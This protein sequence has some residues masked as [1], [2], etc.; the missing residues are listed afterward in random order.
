MCTTGRPEA[1]RIFL[2]WKAAA[3]WNV[4][5]IVSMLAC[6]TVVAQNLTGEIDG[7]VRDASGS[8]IPNASITIRNA[9]Q[10]LVVRT[11]RSDQQGQFTV[12]LL[13]VGHYSLSAIAVGF[14]T[15]TINGIDVHVNQSV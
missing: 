15:A 10:N 6:S 9:D 2:R 13:A 8:A 14:Q 11:V 3:A 5:L 12:P 7:T 4:T 1:I